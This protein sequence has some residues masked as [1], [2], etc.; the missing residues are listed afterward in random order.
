[1]VSFHIRLNVF[2]WCMK[3]K[4]CIE[5]SF[6]LYGRGRVWDD[7]GNVME[8]CIISY[9]KRITSQVRYR[10]LGAGALG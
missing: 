1:M 7:L 6:G 9:K 8:T 2:A 3:R 4:R 10:I 5:Q